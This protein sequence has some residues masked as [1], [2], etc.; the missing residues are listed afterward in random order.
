MS[1]PTKLFIDTCILDGC[2]Y[3]FESASVQPIVGVAK[4]KS[5]SLLLPDA[6]EREMLRH[7]KAQS[8]D[9]L[10]ALVTAQQRAPFLRKWKEWPL[11][12]KQDFL[13]AYNL[14]R[15][16][17]EEFTEF[18]SAFTVIKLDLTTVNL[19]EVMEWYE[20]GLGPFAKGKKKAEF[21]DAFALSS[22][23]TY[24]RKTGEPVAVV[25]VDDDFRSACALHDCLFFHK[26]I[27]SYV[28][29]LL[30]SDEHVKQVRAILD[31]DPETVSKAIEL[32]F[33]ELR[34]YARDD[35]SAELRDPEVEDVIF[36]DMN[37]T[38]VGDREV[39]VSFEAEVTYSIHATYEEMGYFGGRGDEEAWGPFVQEG[40]VRNH[41]NVTGMAKLT[42]DDNWSA[43]TSLD[44]I[45]LD[46]NSI[47]VRL[48]KDY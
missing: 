12:A 42:V 24:S 17:K 22:L 21:P 1:V 31:N 47:S 11:K 29:C 9:V 15:L 44:L 5:I 19:R 48:E 45:T 43:F 28:E 16:A 34:F 27:G 26:S 39:S 2:S 41:C 3:N 35:E 40:R 4:D 36:T 25:S 8:D 33:V 37:V 14:N 46:D 23:L 10:A 32:E 7:I 30:L 18:L 6:T 13:L 20:K 38:G